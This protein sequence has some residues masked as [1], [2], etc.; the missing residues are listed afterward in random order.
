M[1]DFVIAVPER[2]ARILDTLNDAGFE[3]YVVGGCVRD[4]LLGRIPSDW[5][6]TT[7]A[8]P[9]EV[10]AL[11]RRTV[12]TGI[13]HGTVTVL[14][15]KESYEVTTY[16]IDGSYGDGRHPDSVTFT[17][18]LRED[19]MRRDFTVN[20]MA[21]SPRDGL[22]D[23]FDGT[24]DMQKH[25]LRA[26]GDPEER[27]REDALRIMRA[28]R[29]SAQLDYSIEEKTLGALSGLVP[30]LRRI[31]AER[32]R[33]ELSKL[34]LSGHPEK[35]FLLDETGILDVIMPELAL[36]LKTPQ[37]N[38]HHCFN[39]GEHIIRSVCAVRADQVLRLTML[40]HDLGKPACRTTDEDGIDHFHGHAQVSA[41]LALSI[42]KRLKYDNASIDDVVLLVKNH[43]LKIEDD[44]RSVRRAVNRVGE[45]M[46]PLLLEVKRADLAAQSDYQ[47]EEK[48]RHLDRIEE[49]FRKV[50]EEKD[51]VS[52]KTLAVG[53]RELMAWGEKPG[54]EM[55]RVLQA[56][57]DDVL[58]IPGHNERTYLEQ[59]YR[60][61]R[62]RPEDQPA[63]EDH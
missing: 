58:E 45:R 25:V 49:L 33:T 6:I 55:G 42:M 17:G 20:A 40:F 26:V 50:L 21:Y 47:R 53:G 48:A 1:T 28:V 16:R 12:P 23:F 30:T 19:L 60:A 18:S 8:R 41:D 4:S 24:G 44:A 15:G 9:E 57:L 7:S 2:C 54:R 46:F 43:D 51:C 5:D 11:F 56:M 52:L 59:A 32:I 3:A 14:S 36:C 29:F 63:E 39:V 13:K 34:L 27:F 10:T 31:S 35:L 22:V 38:P 61:G 62:Y 37:H